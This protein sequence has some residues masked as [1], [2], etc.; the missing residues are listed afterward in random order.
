MLLRLG[1]IDLV[2]DENLRALRNLFAVL[3]EFRVDLVVVLDRVA[4]LEARRVD[5]VQNQLRAP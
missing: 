2:R 3:L 1:Q 5:D 4:A